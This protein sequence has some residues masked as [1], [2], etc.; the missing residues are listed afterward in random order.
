MRTSN[1]IAAVAA[2][3]IAV[4]PDLAHA[5]D[6]D[7]DTIPDLVDPC[8][9]FANT[10][11]LNGGT[12]CQ[13]V[14]Q[15]GDPIDPNGDCNGDGIPN[16]C[17]CGD[18]TLDGLIGFDD[19]VCFGECVQETPGALCNCNHPLADTTLDGTF[20]FDDVTRAAQALQLIL[21]FWELR[22]ARRPEGTEPP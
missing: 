7:G 11:P 5:Q 19:A 10:L 3:L 21:P 9:S 12:D 22:C 6:T 16:E 20:G 13:T 2:I 8:P 4:F 18:I 1:F 14:S 17:Q 15:D